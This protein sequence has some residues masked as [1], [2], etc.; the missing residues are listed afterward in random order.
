[1]QEY[2]DNISRRKQEGTDLT[3]AVTRVSCTCYLHPRLKKIYF[4][5]TTLRSNIMDI[6]K[7]TVTYCSTLHKISFYEDLKR[8]RIYLLIRHFSGFYLGKILI[9]GRRA[10]VLVVYGTSQKYRYFLFNL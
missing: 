4:K 9:E 6:M 8:H 1:M 3:V 7:V 10:V 5:I 2:R